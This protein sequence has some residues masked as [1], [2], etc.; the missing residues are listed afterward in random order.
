M[1]LTAS[2]YA[3]WILTVILEGVLCAIVVH[4]R[5]WRRLPLFTTYV[6]F[7]FLVTTALW[8]IYKR[9]GYDSDFARYFYWSTES[10]LLVTRAS[11]CAELCLLAFKNRL[12]LWVHAR[13]V[14]IS[15]TAAIFVYAAIDAYRQVYFVSRIILSSE[16]GLELS[17]AILLTSFLLIAGRYR[18]RIERAPSLIAVGVCVHSAFKILN[19]SLLKPWL[20]PHFSSWNNVQAISFQVALVIWLFAL[21]KPLPEAQPAPTLL[22]K[23]AYLSYAQL[24]GPRLKD[25]DRHVQEVMKP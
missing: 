21:R 22:P 17:V 24:I 7:K 13:T 2:A 15:I 23:D 1:H 11:V 4:R 20:D 16:R 8:L 18:I 12:G 19:D 14:L 3:L 25:L 9:F 10:L 5:L 6:I